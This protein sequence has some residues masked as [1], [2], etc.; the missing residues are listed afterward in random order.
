[1]SNGLIFARNMLDSNDIVSLLQKYPPVPDIDD[2]PFRLIPDP[3]WE[4]IPYRK[5]FLWHLYK[6]IVYHAAKHGAEIRSVA[7][8]FPR[9]FT[10][11]MEH[12]YETEL[13][14][15]FDQHGGIPHFDIMT[16]S[17]AVQRWMLHDQ[18]S[19]HPL[20]L[21]IGGGST[22][23]LGL[24]Q[25]RRIQAS[26]ELAAGCV[27]KYFTE[28][29]RFQRIFKEAI[30]HVVPLRAGDH[31]Q[32]ARR[33]LLRELYSGLNSGRKVEA[34]YSEQAFFRMLNMMEGHYSQIVDFLYDLPEGPAH[35]SDR[36]AVAGFFHTLALL[37]TGIIFQAGRLLK[38]DQHN[39]T[40][41]NLNIKFIGNGSRFYH[42]LDRGVPF[43][44]VLAGIFCKASGQRPQLEVDLEPAGKT[45]VAKGMLTP[46]S[47][48]EI[49]AAVAEDKESHRFLLRLAEEANPPVP[50]KA[51]FP[52]LAAFL[53]GL[54]SELP[55]GKLD[56]LTV[57]P[58][59]QRNLATEL[60]GTEAGG[61]F[62]RIITYVHRMELEKAGDLKRDWDEAEDLARTSL[63]AAAPARD[64]ALAA[65][66]VFIIQLKCLLDVIRERYADSD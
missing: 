64:S 57:I 25:E 26:Y 18:P 8:S 23:L 12:N 52:E 1:M 47:S 59:C 30:E 38:P 19:A 24:F 54:S 20:V 3:K 31:L 61:L 17:D 44:K 14:T 63:T 16:E 2:R 27:N 7:F 39:I 28:S 22:D 21:D 13:S 11:A 10:K 45:Y 58:Y 32:R 60:G 33:F 66:P 40:V 55:G 4:H 50:Q 43:S 42:F 49:R 65:E 15:I 5:P 41:R 46:T 9:A 51:E 56:G 37:Y 48:T 35:Q 62:D 29:P 34:S 36:M 6:M 53:E